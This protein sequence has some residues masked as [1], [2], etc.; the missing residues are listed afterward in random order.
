VA[1]QH[2]AISLDLNGDIAAGT[3]LVTVI[4]GDQRYVERLV[5]AD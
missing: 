3:Y 1:A 2:G 4:A 5:I